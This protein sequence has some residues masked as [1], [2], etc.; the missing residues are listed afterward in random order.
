M[1]LTDDFSGPFSAAAIDELISPDESRHAVYLVGRDVGGRFVPHALGRCATGLRET[2]RRFQHPEARFM[3]AY[4]GHEREAF[5]QQ[6]VLYHRHHLTL[7]T[8][9]HPHRP[10]HAD[11]RCPGC[12]LY[13]SSAPRGQNP[14][15]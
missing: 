8:L 2:L 12:T 15:A 14:S 4:F 10:L 6:C 3:V 1:S 13:N 11:W 9:A 7:G 5:R